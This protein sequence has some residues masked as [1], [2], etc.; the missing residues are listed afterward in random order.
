MS[1]YEELRELFLAEMPRREAIDLILRMLPIKMK[2]AISDYLEPPSGNAMWPTTVYRCPTTYVDFY[3]PLNNKNGHQ[4]WERCEGDCCLRL[5][6]GGIYSFTIG[7]C[8]ENTPG[9]MPATMLYFTFSVEKF[10]EQSV[11]LQIKNLDGAILIDDVKDPRSYANA[12]KVS[13]DRLV[14]DLKNPLSARGS[15]GFVTR[16]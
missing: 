4:T 11:E 13:I 8:I 12:A 10:D 7:V 9:S 1:A 6:H 16:A 3:S 5:E 15:I 2:Q 14:S